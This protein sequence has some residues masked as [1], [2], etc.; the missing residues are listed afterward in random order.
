MVPFSCEALQWFKLGAGPKY[1][2][3]IQANSSPVLGL[4][5][6]ERTYWLY[7]VDQKAK[8]Q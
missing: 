2:D 7:A 3:N 1:I 5:I 6:E 8:T 4:Q